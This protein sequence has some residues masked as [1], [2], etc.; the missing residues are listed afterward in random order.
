MQ[1]PKSRTP[2]VLARAAKAAG[3]EGQLYL[4][5]QGADPTSWEQ[6]R[7]NP[8]WIG[9]SA[10]FPERYGDTGIPAIIKLIKGEDPG[11]LLT[12]HEFVDK[13]NIDQIYP[14]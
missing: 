5:A 10:Y 2:S 11:P 9:D 3:R 14:Q 7:T 4:A 12:N 8:N 6:I 1:A 13:S